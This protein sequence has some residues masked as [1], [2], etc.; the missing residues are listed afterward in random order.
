MNI[1]EFKYSRE[2][3]FKEQVEKLS[4]DEKKYLLEHAEYLSQTK[5]LTLIELVSFKHND[6]YPLLK[7]KHY[8]LLHHYNL[9]PKTKSFESSILFYAFKNA[10]SDEELLKFLK[11][12]RDNEYQMSTD[13]YKSLCGILWDKSYKKSF[14]SLLSWKQYFFVDILL[15]FKRKDKIS[16]I[17]YCLKR[18]IN[19]DIYSLLDNDGI[20][21][22]KVDYKYKVIK[23]IK[24]Q[25]MEILTYDLLVRSKFDVDESILAL[26]HKSFSLLEIDDFNHCFYIDSYSG[27][28]S[29]KYKM[30]NFMINY[31]DIANLDEYTGRMVFSRLLHFAFEDVDKKEAKLNLKYLSLAKK[32]IRK[33]FLIYKDNF[34]CDDL[35][36]WISKIYILCK[37]NLSERDQKAF[38]SFYKKVQDESFLPPVIKEILKKHDVNIMYFDIKI[39]HFL[40]RV[41]TEKELR[42]KLFKQDN[43]KIKQF[44]YQNIVKN[45]FINYVLLIKTYWAIH[46]LNIQWERW[47]HYVEHD[48][49]YTDDC[50]FFL[51]ATRINLDLLSQLKKHYSEKKIIMMLLNMEFCDYE[52]LRKTFLKLRD[53]VDKKSLFPRQCKNMLDLST[54][55]QALNSKVKN[56]DYELDVEDYK[57]LGEYCIGDYEIIIPQTY[58]ELLNYGLLMKNCLVTEEYSKKVGRKYIVLFLKKD[59]KIMYSISFNEGCMSDAKG[60]A[61]TEMPLD[62]V[63]PVTS[64]FNSFRSTNL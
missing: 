12:L 18:K 46:Y 3:K 40:K 41:N 14:F 19:F 37:D 59:N 11:R 56:D 29:V 17:D 33:R 51:E 9:S 6:L 54:Y 24:T 28:E 22:L 20:Y 30:L 27:L 44:F 5:V 23:M 7:T 39:L 47:I 15:R 16:I 60:I 32:M 1:K 13:E 50:F 4:I 8:K 31:F 25:S 49:H 58:Y 62:L 61:N 63:G 21:H 42:V 43:K 45:G 2:D 34:V 53:K 52:I 10:S 35:I 57:G 55:V 38:E 36:A 48:I 64:L 26:F